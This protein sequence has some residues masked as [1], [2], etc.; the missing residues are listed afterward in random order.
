MKSRVIL[1]IQAEEVSIHG[2]QCTCVPSSETGSQTSRMALNTPYD[3]ASL[4]LAAILPSPS[5]CWG[6]RNE[7]PRPV[8]ALLD[9]NPRPSCILGKLY[10]P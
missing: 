10:S 8:F 7:P 2:R 3:K 4:E 5:S 6:G 1:E 9:M